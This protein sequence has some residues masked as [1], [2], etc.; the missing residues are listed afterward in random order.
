[1][2]FYDD[3]ALPRIGTGHNLPHY[4]A[5]VE[6]ET[7]DKHYAKGPKPMAYFYRGIARRP[8]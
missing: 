4:P 2:G 6:I 7:L 5:G 3:W 1:M 8:S